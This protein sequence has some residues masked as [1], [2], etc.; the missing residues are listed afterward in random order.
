MKY[1]CAK[2][3][4]TI[5]WHEPLLFCPFCGSSYQAAVQ[6]APIAATRIVVG[7]DSE[8]TIQKKYWREAQAV[9]TLLLKTLKENLPRFSQRRKKKIAWDAEMPEHTLR[10]KP[11]AAAALQGCT[12]MDEFCLK[13]EKLL[14][15]VQQLLDRKNRLFELA[16]QYTEENR[17]I[18]AERKRMLENRTWSVDEFEDEYSIDILA[19]ANLI[20]QTCV[21]TA[22]VL[23]ST[24]AKELCP[25]VVYDPNSTQWLEGFDEGDDLCVQAFQ[26]L[27]KYAALWKEI[28]A[29][30]A[31]MISVLASNGLFSLSCIHKAAEEDFDPEQCAADLQL[32]RKQDY[33]PLFGESPESFICAF[34]DGLVSLISFCDQAPADE[35]VAAIWPAMKLHALKSE[36]DSIRLTALRTLISKWS[37]VLQLE[38]DKLYQSQSKDMLQVC[39]AIKDIQKSIGKEV[40]S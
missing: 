26:L 29:S 39:N 34:F 24:L 16:Q 20:E 31:A 33:D 36:L 10:L 9:V 1:T 37:D 25:K 4:S 18:A 38:L 12:A 2:C 15:E 40:V 19:E 35:D 7:S 32:L 17:R 6:T 27:P 13:F 22:A 8:R 21:E 11:N 28:E 3:N 23:G 30:S 5:K 14:S